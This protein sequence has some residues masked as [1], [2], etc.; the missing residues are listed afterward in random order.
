MK[1]GSRRRSQRGLDR[2]MLFLL[3]VVLLVA[4]VPAGLGLVGL[5]PR[6]EA[7]SSAPVGPAPAQGVGEDVQILSARGHGVDGDRES[8]GAVTLLVASPSGASLDLADVT[9]TWIDNGTYRLGHRSASAGGIDGR[10][11]GGVVGERDGTTVLREG[12]R[13]RIV[14][15]LGTDDVRGVGSVA[16]RLRA[17]GR[18]S[19]ILE[20][21]SGERVSRDLL[22]PPELPADGS[23]NL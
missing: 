4:V 2:L 20:L 16:E 11:D 22:V 6:G 12:D 9:V 8:I 14:V 3:A 23:V 10:F 21:A 7:P 5:D 13:G 15:D 17:G 19:L 1:P 18:A